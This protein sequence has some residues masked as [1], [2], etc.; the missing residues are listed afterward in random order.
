[1]SRGRAPRSRSENVPVLSV[2]PSLH[3]VTSQAAPLGPSLGGDF[4]LNTHLLVLQ[5]GSVIPL[6]GS[7][8]GRAEGGAPREGSVRAELTCRPTFS[9]W[10][11][12]PCSSH[13]LGFPLPRPYQ[14]LSWEKMPISRFHAG[15][16]ERTQA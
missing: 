8:S 12:T 14:E 6:P 16:S 3:G 2:A 15:V 5:A 13:A 4:H 11:A 9:G 1:M 7:C 10:A